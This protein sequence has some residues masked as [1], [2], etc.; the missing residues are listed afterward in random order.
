MI[1]LEMK[2][3]D[4]KFSTPCHVTDGVQAKMFSN[5]EY[6]FDIKDYLKQHFNCNWGN[7]PDDDKQLNDKAFARKFGDMMSVYYLGNTK[8]WIY[9]QSDWKLTTIL[10]PEEW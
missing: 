1:S 8:I 3:K 10:L 6:L 9:T 7:I 4:I 2:D 5:P